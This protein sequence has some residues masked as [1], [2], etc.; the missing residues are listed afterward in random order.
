MGFGAKSLSWMEGFTFS[1]SMSVITNGSTTKDF[2]VKKGL[3]QGDPLFHFLFVLE[4]DVLTALMR[5][6][7][8]NN[9][10]RGFK[11]NEVENVN[12]LQFADDT[13]ILEEGDTANLWRMKEI[14]RGFEMMS[15]LR[16]NFNKSNIY[17]VNVC[18]GFIEATSTF[19]SCKVDILP[20]I[21]LGVKVGGNPQTLAMWKD[22]I[23]MLK[24]RL[25]VWKGINLNTVRRQKAYHWVSWDIVCKSRE[26]GGL[27]V[28][29]V[30]VMNV[31]LLSKWKWKILVEEEA[32]WRGILVSR[33]GNIKL[34]IL[35]GDISIAEKSDYIWWRD[36]LIFDNYAALLNQKF[37]GAI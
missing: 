21:F 30:E 15:G 11:I 2:K 13:V 19:V 12:M 34:K 5:K 25:A 27:G 14:L 17:G 23:I 3:H 36:I 22:L 6:A 33:Y 32:V 10:F 16:V 9:D 18:D 8:S 24:W 35:V 37:S 4:T 1:S 20:F 31:A 29:N 7:I 26:E 28:N